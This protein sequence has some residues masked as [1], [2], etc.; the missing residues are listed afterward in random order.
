MNDQLDALLALQKVDA[1]ILALEGRLGLL[2]PRLGRLDA[3]RQAVAAALESARVAVARESERHRH[4]GERAHEFRRLNERALSQLDQ[5]RKA[6][7][8]E[9]AGAQVDISRRA[10]GDAE[11]EL[12]TSGQRLATLQG[13]LAAAEQRVAAVDAEH[14][15]M[16]AR[17]AEERDAIAR[18]LD[19]ARARRAEAARPVN[20]RLLWQYDKVHARRRGP[21]VFALHHFTC[22]NCDTAIPTQRRAAMTAGAIEVCESCGVLLHAAPPAAAAGAEPTV[23]GATAALR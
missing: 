17:A 2:A 11:A 5:V 20:A 10:L 23:A 21:A 18:E 13:V 22:G 3:E 16:R 7:H 9:A 19:G 1:E 15:P 8:A 6:Q 14:E 12:L 4:L